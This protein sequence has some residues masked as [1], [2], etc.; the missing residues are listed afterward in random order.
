[1]NNTFTKQDLRRIYKEK[2]N[3]LFQDGFISE[4]SDIICK[5]LA[6]CIFFKS[7]KNIL[8]Y[9]PKDSE[10][11]TLQLLKE[12][13]KKFYLPRCYE[14]NL[15]ICKYKMGDEL[16]LNKY[17]IYE[18]VCEPISDLGILD[19]VVTPALCA[20]KNF[21]RIGYGAGYYDRLFSN[22]NIKAKKVI[23]I[24]DKML[25]EKIHCDT[26]DKK[27]DIIITEKRILENFSSY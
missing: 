9:Y 24:P 25:L 26:Y 23:I 11:N 6:R 13:D 15:L 21:H 20:D 5:K 27:C 18:P 22:K 16:L 17:K 12:Q 7:A 3:A 4:I 8:I 14:N 10:L 19:I 2:R 1:M